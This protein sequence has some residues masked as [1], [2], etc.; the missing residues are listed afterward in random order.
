VGQLK[1]PVLAFGKGFGL[2]ADVID[3]TPVINVGAD[4]P[5]LLSRLD[6]SLPGIERLH[7]KR[8]KELA[9][10]YAGQYSVT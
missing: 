7:A 2:F 6:R 5:D 4:G 10:R 8:I 1:K 3:Q 9:E